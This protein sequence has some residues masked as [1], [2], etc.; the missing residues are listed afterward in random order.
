MANKVKPIPEGYHAVTPYLILKEAAKALE[1]YKRAFGATELARLADPSGKIMHAEV[2]IG[3]S[4]IM[5]AD[6]FPDMGIVGPQSLGG[7]S[8][9]LHLYVD[10]V[11]KTFQ[12]A[13]DAGATVKRPIE[14]QFYGDRSGQ[15]V[16]PFGHAWNIAT[17]VEDVTMEEMEKRFAAYV[18]N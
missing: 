3:D 12:T 15:I 11:D 13:I 17:H 7:T 2:K 14:D 16:D 10:D 9:M 4:P 5:L 8:V 18:P 6:E 1:F